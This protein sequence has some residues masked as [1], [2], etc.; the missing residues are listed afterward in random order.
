MDPQSLF[1][2]FFGL[3]SAGMGWFAKTLYGAVQELR[4]DLNALHIELARDYVPVRRFE[5]ATK[6]ISDKL[7]VI[8]EKIAH[9]ADK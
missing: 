5:E 3:A 8:L 9:K 2:A 7:D 1:N 4:K 6:A